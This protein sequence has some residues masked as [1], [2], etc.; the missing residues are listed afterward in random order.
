MRVL[1]IIILS[2]FPMVVLSQNKMIQNLKY[3]FN[4]EHIVVSYDLISASSDSYYSISLLAFGADN[5]Q[6]KPQLIYGDIGDVIHGGTEKK[7]VWQTKSDNFSYKG[8]LRIVLKVKSNLKPKY[9]THLSK[10]IIFPG[11]GDYRLDNKKSHI[12]KGVAGYSLIGLGYF[13]KSQSELNYNNYLNANSSIYANSEFNSAKSNQLLS[14]SAFSLS[15]ALWSY[16]VLNTYFK[17]KK[18]KSVNNISETQSKYYNKL[19]SKEFLFSTENEVNIKG[20]FYPPNLSLVQEDGVVLKNSKGDI[21]KFLNAG[22][23]TTIHF[24]IKN[25]GKGDGNNLLLKIRNQEIT[26]EIKIPNELNL[27]LIK[28]DS[29]LNIEIPVSTELDFE[30]SNLKL[31]LEVIEESGFGLEPFDLNIAIKKFQKPKIIVTDYKFQTEKGGIPSKKD[32]IELKLNVQNVGLGMGEDISVKFIY[33][34][35]I[36]SFSEN[37]KKIY[38]ILNSSEHIELSF[39]FAAT[40]NYKDSVIPI[41]IVLEEKYGRF[42]ESQILKLNLKKELS[43]PINIYGELNTSKEIKPALLHSDVDIDI[44]VNKIKKSETFA[45]IIG[46]EDYKSRQ[47]NLEAESNVDFALNDARIFKEYAINCLGIPNE[48][49]LYLENSTSGE[50]KQSL[51]RLQNLVNRF[52]KENAEIIFYYAGHGFPDETTKVPYLMPVD[53]SVSD[54]SYAIKLDDLFNTLSETN[55]NKITVFLDACFT[56]EG[57]KLGLL[58]ARTARIKP[59]FTSLKGNI[60]VFNAGNGN[61]SAL[62]FKEEKHGYFTYFILKKLKETK[63]EVSYEELSNYV[64]QKVSFE[65][66]R[67]LKPQDPTV[68]VSVSLGE[69]WKKWRFK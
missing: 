8:K 34:E 13:F 10:S 19:S 55:A 42:A 51:K 56:G 12:L 26:S 49:I 53:V 52:G 50:M 29:F 31:Q 41:Q 25:I 11:F 40:N 65:T 17:T 69:K 63:G 59:S 23:L 35:N 48:N 43:K 24:R 6:F 33:P 5:Q 44:P 2:F 28:S 61:Q 66:T 21:T 58:S 15:G 57:R 67:Y 20:V 47:V 3:V 7:I 14:Y 30:S 64:N 27:G 1:V 16:S 18:L 62:P 46:N 38:P 54:L 39:E 37:D 9:S 36:H 60:V 4:G 22:D 45:L 32:K 68:A